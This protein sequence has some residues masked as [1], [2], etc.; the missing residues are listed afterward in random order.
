[1]GVNIN[2]IELYR[3]LEITPIQQNIMLVGRHGIGKSRIITDYFSERGRK[4][5]SL[6]LGQ[7][8]DPGDIIGL[9]SLS[10]DNNRTEFRLPFWFPDDNSP[11]VL[12]LDELNRA[13]P[14]ILQTVMDLVL[15]KT[16]AGKSLPAGS[17]IISAINEGEEYQLTDLDPA[18]LSRFNVYNFSPTTDEWLLWA[19]GR[20]LDKRVIDFISANPDLLDQ[21]VNPDAGLSKTAD[22]RAWERVADLISPLKEIEKETEKAIAGII[23]IQTALKFCAYLKQLSQISAIDIL[24]NFKK[25]ISKLKKAQAHETTLL[26]EAM[27][28]IIETEEEPDK[29]TKY[30]ENLELYIQWLV[31]EKRNEVL[32]HWT[33][34]YESNTYPKSRFKILN[35]SQ[36]IFQ[37]IVSFIKEIKI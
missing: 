3:I 4:V 25:N 29:I 15:N 37:N 9:P 2:T 11:V 7:M 8:S 13:R 22:R 28:R 33:T 12:F 19:T 34:M 20:K 18:L 24:T 5:V 10:S 23:G 14:E 30:I 32:A 26:N 21:P 35:N 27:F 1:M 6:F 36:Y 16:L 17:Q 31:E